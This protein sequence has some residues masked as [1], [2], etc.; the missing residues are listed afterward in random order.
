MPRQPPAQ[1]V[2]GAQ[3][4]GKGEQ[5]HQRDHGADDA[6][7]GGEDGAGDEGG[8][9]EGAGE[10]ADGEL[11]RVEQPVEDVRPLDDVAHEDEERD[12][13]ED[14][15][16]HHRIGALDHEGEDDVALGHVAEHHA[17]RHQGEGD[18]E[19]EHDE[20]HEQDE[21]EHAQFGI[22]DGD[23]EHQAAPFALAASACSRMIFSVSSTSWRRC[24]HSPL[25]RHSTQRT[26]SEA[27]W[28]TMR[29]PTSGMSDL[30]GNT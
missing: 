13:D 14:I 8:D 7:G 24:G 27:P 10:T 20:D 15:V 16:G 29:P 21:H 2:A 1:T 26:T 12:G 23:A 22:A 4:G 30:N 18:G 9:G 28:I 11:H 25:R 3:H 6:G 5:A 17:E 19:A